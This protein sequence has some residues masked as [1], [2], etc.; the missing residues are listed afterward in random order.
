MNDELLD[1][2]MKKTEGLTPSERLLLA[3]RVIEGVR[4]DIPRNTTVPAI[5]G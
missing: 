5:D 3:A 4:K 1:E 2:L